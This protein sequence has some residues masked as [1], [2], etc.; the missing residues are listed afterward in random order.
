M[1]VLEHLG[2]ASDKSY[3]LS[4]RDSLLLRDLFGEIAGFLGVKRRFISVPFPL[5]Y[6]GAWG[7]YVLSLGRMDFR[8]K[9]QR[10]CEDRSYP[11]DEA[12][13]DLGY[14][15]MPFAEGLRLEVDAYL[16]EK[17]LNKK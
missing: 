3:I 4:G 7:I 6:A 17:R 16:Q 2:T 12:A 11:H 10:L 13:R 14:D 8:E 15:P 5:A 9:V 1:Q